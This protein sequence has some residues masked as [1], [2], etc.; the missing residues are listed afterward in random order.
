M[1]STRRKKQSNRRLLSQIDDFNRNM[2]NGNAACEKKEKTVVNEGT[3][4]RDFTVGTSFKNTAINGSTMIMKT[5][6]RCFNEW[7]DKEIS[8]FVDTVE[9]R[10]QNAIFTAIENIV[11]PKIELAVRSINASSGRDVTSVAA[12]SERGEHVRT[13]ASFENA[14]RSNNLL[15]VFEVNDETGHKIPDEVSELS[16]PETHSERQAHTHHTTKGQTMQTNQIPEFL[17]GRILTTRN[18]PS[19]QH[20]TLTTQVSQDNNLPMVEQTTINEKSDANNS[21][22]RLPNNNPTTTTSSYNAKASI[23]KYNNS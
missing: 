1:V 20:Q 15:H 11:A 18:P 4:D 13:N 7:I 23:Y 19:H 6:G 14:S 12:N 3:N 5:L 9:N 21:L 8:K 22:N 2:V 16:V 10:I 17:T